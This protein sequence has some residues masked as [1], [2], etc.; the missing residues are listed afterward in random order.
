MSVFDYLKPVSSKVI[1]L[2]SQLSNQTIGGKIAVHS[3]TEVPNLEIIK[4]AIIGV[5]DA[6]GGGIH[7]QVTID[8]FRENFYKLYP[9]NWQFDFADLGNIEMGNTVSD[10]H[11][12]VS[13]VVSE[14]IKK[15]IVPIIIGGSQDI[16]YGMY[17]A[18]DH[19]DQMVNFVNID[20]KFDFESHEN[21]LYKNTFLH[22]MVLDKPNNLFHYVNIGF[23]TYLNSQEEIDLMEKLYFDAF[24]LG[25]VSSDVSITEPVFRDADLVSVDLTSIKSSDSSNFVS[26][27]PNGFDGKEICSLVRYAGISD[28][29]TSIGFFNTDYHPNE[30]L[31][32]SQM[33]WYFV[34]GYSC[35]SNE[36]PFNVEK[37]ATKFIVI[38]DSDEMVFYKS[39]ISGRWW[40]EMLNTNN[41]YNNH[42]K[43]TLL[44]CSYQDYLDACNQEIPEIWWKAQRKS[45]L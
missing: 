2:I 14:L 31:L 21:A 20:K 43:M 7:D 35:R 1:S 12:A 38:I 19:L 6:R 3:V 17:R 11:F 42:K 4:L 44:P 23:Q 24:R 39:N 8:P 36:Y 28:K 29:T 37:N 13:K 32:L 34:E 5:L 10:T 15:S 41:T 40:L 22:K 9:G 18:Y 30:F 45:I 16:T 25:D 27:A 26:F 33:V